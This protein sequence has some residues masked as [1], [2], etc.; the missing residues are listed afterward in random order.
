[1]KFSMLLPAKEDPAK[2]NIARQIGVDY[3]I[4]KASTELSGLPDPSDFQALQRVKNAFNKA[5]FTLYGLEGDQF[6]MSPIKLAK[7]DRDKTIEKYQQMLRNMGELEIPLLCYNFM[8]S[9]G[10]FRTRVDIKERGGALVSG[11]YNDEVGNELLNPEDC[12]TEN[13]LWDNLFYFLDAVLPVAQEAGVTMALHPDDP[14]VSPLKGVGRILTSPQA[15]EKVFERFPIQ[16]NAITFCQAT[17]GLMTDNVFALAEK[18]LK[19]DRIAFLHLRDVSGDKYNFRETF[20]DN[21]QTDMAAMMLLYCKHGFKGPV[22]PD[23]APAMYGEF[24][25][26]FKGSTSVGYGISGKI[27]AIGYLKGLYDVSRHQSG[28]NKPST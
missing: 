11:F 8:A 12:V 15:F 18:W 14:P 19:A 3:A 5:G 17:F 2:W 16:H 24:Q 22:R 21:G 25:D 28:S 1:M 13:Q 23:H 4:T 10:W 6:D 7:P 27:F 9:I 20:H 26:E